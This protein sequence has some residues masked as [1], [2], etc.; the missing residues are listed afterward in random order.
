MNELTTP[1]F[2]APKIAAAMRSPVAGLTIEAVRS[3]NSTNAD[4][5]ARVG[6]MAAPVLLVAD[7]QLAGRGR[8]GRTWHSQAHASLTCSLA[9]RFNL[10]IQALTG[11]PLVV[12]I[13]LADALAARGDSVQ[14]KW[15]NDLL[16]DGKKLG[17]VLIETAADPHAANVV[18]AV[19][20]IGINMQ[21]CATL[22]AELGLPIASLSA[23]AAE[24]RD[25]LLAGLLDHLGRE[26]GQFEKAG[27]GIFVSRWNAL[28]AHRDQPV[29]IIDR[30]RTLFDGVARG[31]DAQGCLLL[32]TADGPRAVVAGDVSLR[33]VPV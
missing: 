33:T 12:G 22:D 6:Q 29:R 16:C 9:W 2:S 26:L 5:L 31:V 3:T 25:A 4:L 19:I 15:P 1:L 8:A 32:D 27:F 7:Q 18:W 14:L 30:G 20:G 17:G 10:P 11:L 21:H 13:A 28:H 23:M 24:D